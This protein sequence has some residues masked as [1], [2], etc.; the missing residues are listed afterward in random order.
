[1]VDK[2]TIIKY[3]GLIVIHQ[4]YATAAAQCGNPKEEVKSKDDEPEL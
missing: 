1:M 4:W 3:S 2:P